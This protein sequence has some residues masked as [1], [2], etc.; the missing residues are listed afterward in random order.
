MRGWGFFT[1]GAA[2][3]FLWGNV[4]AQA[5]SPEYFENCQALVQA[6]LPQKANLPRNLTQNVGLIREGIQ[7]EGEKYL[8]RLEASFEGGVK[9]D[10]R[11]RLKW[12][13]PDLQ[14]ESYEMEVLPDTRFEK[15]YHIRVNFPLKADGSVKNI[16]LLQ[17]AFQFLFSYLPD[18]FKLHWILYD[19]VLVDNF[20]DQINEA[21]KKLGYFKAPVRRLSSSQDIEDYLN[22]VEYQVDFERDS[23]LPAHTRLEFDEFIN[24]LE[25]SHL[26]ALDRAKSFSATRL[27][28]MLRETGSWGYDFTMRVFETR[29]N[30][31]APLP[32]DRLG[33]D[34]II[35]VYELILSP[36]W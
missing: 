6:I 27:A 9:D 7:I 36:N 19:R 26:L 11:L 33:E 16:D 14:G 12:K 5:M 10:L 30:R 22:G 28:K 20:N 17:D 23:F 31:S 13:T 1:A 34:G 25:K 8:R 21:A 35:Y 18:D 2:G 29:S 32:P 4:Q 3:F 24:H 15:R